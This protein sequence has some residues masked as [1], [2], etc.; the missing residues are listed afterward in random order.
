MEFDSRPFGQAMVCVIK[1]RL[2][3]NG[4]PEFESRCQPLLDGE[5][6][7]LVVDMSGLEFVSSA[8]LRAIIS[9]GKR[10]KAK[11]VSLGFCGMSEMVRDVFEIAG[12]LGLFPAWGTVEEALR[13]P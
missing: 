9:M 7:M 6:K 1:G 4:A 2:D 10:A 11:G 13:Q 3:V 12:M 5:H 8:G